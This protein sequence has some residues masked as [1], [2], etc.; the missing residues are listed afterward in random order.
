MKQ[1]IYNKVRALAKGFSPFYL[2]T[3][4]P[5]FAACSDDD[6]LG[7]HYTEDGAGTQMNVT[8]TINAETNPSLSWQEGDIIGISTGYGA[9]DATARNRGY[10][11]QQDGS[12]FIQSDGN[13]MYVK[14]ATNITAYYPYIGSDGAEPTITL[15][16]RNQNNITDYL[17]AKA[18]GVTPAN[19]SKVNLV[20]DYA[21]A[22]LQMKFTVPQGES[23]KSCRL[24]GFAQ[25]ATVDPYTLNATLNAPEDLV[26]TGNNITSLS[27]KLIP[28]TIEAMPA[29]PAQLILVGSI[30]SYT[31][32]MSDLTFTGGE[33]VQATVDVTSGVGTLE[34]VPT[35][36]PWSD[37]GVGG[38]TNSN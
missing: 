28:Q 23:I 11:C 34:F 4:L 15:D 1:N 14:G 20:F 37:S 29:V 38:N 21:L 31:I 3:L 35:G 6:Y 8:A 9:Y 25:Q 10:I 16:T 5:F 26:V 33:L 7:G 36:A 27:L 32:D 17:F 2:F 30:R 24:T 19:G 22:R 18:E 12:T 13:A